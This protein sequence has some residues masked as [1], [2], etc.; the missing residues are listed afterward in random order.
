MK[1]E[2]L[3]VDDDQMIC[4]SIQ[5]A[6]EQESFS[7]VFANDGLEALEIFKRQYYPLVIT[8][9]YMPKMGGFELMQNLNQFEEKPLVL[10]QSVE[11]DLE[12]IITYLQQGAFDYFIKPYDKRKFVHR[13]KKALEVAELRAIKKNLEK[14]REIR[15]SGIMN[16]N[17]WKEKILKRDQEK[18]DN[19]LIESM[20]TAFS[21]GIGFGSLISVV[22]RITK[23]AKPEDGF[24]RVPSP[25]MEMLF[26]NSKA[27]N[28]IINFF[29]ELEILNST[30]NFE[31]FTINEFYNILKIYIEKEMSKLE[32]IKNN[33]IILNENKFLH[34]NYKIKIEKD[35]VL[36]AIKEVLINAFKFSKPESKVYLTMQVTGN[37]FTISIL[38]SPMPDQNGRTGIPEEYS[39]IVLEPFFRMSKF[40]YE[41]FPSLDFGLGLTFVDRV[42]TKHS[43][44]VRLMNLKS[45]I[46]DTADVITSVELELP[47]YIF[48][49]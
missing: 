18:I 47:I 31:E 1:P 12:T 28:R 21:Q 17:V 10:L 49:P 38:N 33:T 42:M 36:N 19:S 30:R 6:V 16:W 43:G 22:N 24:Y 40:V 3:F 8:D 44:R 48:N 2:I 20:R 26:E 35:N 4:E 13:V 7:I 45:H 23:K 25:L 11:T 32:I 14:E 15:F 41:E 39:S 46:P 5:T 27:A 29:E 9:L 37:K 34:Y